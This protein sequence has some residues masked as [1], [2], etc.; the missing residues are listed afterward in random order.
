MEKAGRSS[1]IFKTVHVPYI[2]Q[3]NFSMLQQRRQVNATSMSP[4]NI[5]APVLSKEAGATTL[6]S[7]PNISG[8]LPWQFTLATFSP[9]GSHES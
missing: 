7:H 8:L 2:R 4:H 1:I 3:H 6:A 9:P 5:K